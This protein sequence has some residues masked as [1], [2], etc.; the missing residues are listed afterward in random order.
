MTKTLKYKLSKQMN[1]TH[2]VRGGIG[3]TIFSSNENNLPFMYFYNLREKT[4]NEKDDEKK[5]EKKDE[6]KY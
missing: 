3:P 6:E 4:E 2:K 5:D 1:R